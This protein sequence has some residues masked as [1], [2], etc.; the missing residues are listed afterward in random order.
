MFLSLFFFFLFLETWRLVLTLSVALLF[1]MISR[2]LVS[3]IQLRAIWRP[4]AAA[5]LIPCK[6]GW[7]CSFHITDVHK[8]NYPSPVQV[9]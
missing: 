7:L 1:F 9:L 6:A 5:S 3:T 8:S 4:S 2:L